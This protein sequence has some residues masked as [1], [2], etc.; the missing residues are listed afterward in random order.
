MHVDFRFFFSL[1]NL[2]DRRV[3]VNINL[4]VSHLRAIAIVYRSRAEPHALA[5]ATSRVSPSESKKI[6]LH[7]LNEMEDKG[8]TTKVTRK[9]Q[10]FG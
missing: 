3:T 7:V 10:L 5:L 6:M 4:A 9:M 2:N 1:S 8:I